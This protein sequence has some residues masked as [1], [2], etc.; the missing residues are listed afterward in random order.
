MALSRNFPNC[1]KTDMPTPVLLFLP[2]RWDLTNYRVSQKSVLIEQNHNQSW[3]KSF[4]YSDI[5][6]VLVLVRNNQKTLFRPKWCQPLVIVPEGASWLQQHSIS[7]FLGTPCTYLLL[8][9]TATI[10]SCVFFQASALF[11]HN[12]RKILAY[13]VARLRNF[14]CTFT[15]LNNGVVSQDGKILGRMMCNS[16]LCFIPRYTFWIIKVANTQCD[17]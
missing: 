8:V 11:L 15:G 10:S 2:P 12:E 1:Q 6:E 17:I 5:V 16:W 4:Y 9:T 7:T 13:I 3:V 14:W